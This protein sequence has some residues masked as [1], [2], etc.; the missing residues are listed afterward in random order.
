GAIGDGRWRRAW[1]AHQVAVR[2]LVGLALGLGAFGLYWWVGPTQAGTDAYIPLADAMLHGRVSLDPMHYTWVELA[3]YRGGWFVPFPPVPAVVL[4]PFVAVFGQTFDTNLTAAIAGGIGVWLM[5]GMLR[6]LGL[7]L[8][9]ALALTVA[10][11]VG[12]EVFWASA[13]GGTHLFAETLAATLLLA[14]LRLALARRAPILAGLLLGAAIGCRLPLVFALPLVVGLYVGLPTRIGRPSARQ[15]SRVVEIGFG[16]AGPALMIAVYNYA[17]FRSPIEFGYGLITSRDGHSVLEEPWYSHGIVSPLYLPGGLW[18]MLGK[19]WD[20]VGEFPWLHPTW[21]GQAVTFTTPL[22]VWLA[23]ARFR[24]P[25]V[26]YALV[27]AALILLVDLIHGGT[28]YAQFGYRFIVD[29]LPVLWLVL[30]TVFRD[31]LGRWAVVAGA[32]GIAAFAYGMV[33]IWGFNYVGS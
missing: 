4:L 14:T 8:R 7:N 2:R 12:S 30:A 6:Q 18:A 5:W 16:L 1:T 25:L 26:A 20:I 29:G 28:G 27:S 10:W 22:L 23:R 33:A 3:L 9:S 19:P 21:A 13:V 31:G 32:L 15:L 24:N 11:A 17:R